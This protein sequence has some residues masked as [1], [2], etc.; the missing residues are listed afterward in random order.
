VR[1]QVQG[2]VLPVLGRP[3]PAGHARSTALSR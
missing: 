1:G 3:R 2:Q